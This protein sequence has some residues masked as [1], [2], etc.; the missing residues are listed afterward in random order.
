MSKLSSFET[1]FCYPFPPPK[2]MLM[3]NALYHSQSQRT[4]SVCQMCSTQIKLYFVFQKQNAQSPVQCCRAHHAPCSVLVQQDPHFVFLNSSGHIFT[5]V[6]CQMCCFH[7]RQT[8][9]F[10]EGMKQFSHM[11]NYNFKK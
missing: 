9:R 8:S 1:L 6:C 7:W 10:G 4:F 2:Q 3:Q 5:S 11:G